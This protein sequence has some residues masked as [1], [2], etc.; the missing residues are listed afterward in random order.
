VFVLNPHRYEISIYKDFKC[1]G[2]IQGKSDVFAKAESPG[3]AKGRAF[4]FPTA[5]VQ[6][7]GRRIYVT[8]RKPAAKSGHEMDIFEDGRQIGRLT[9]SGIPYAVDAQGR[10][11]FA[12]EEGF[13]RI[14]RYIVEN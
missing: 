7:A 6:E 10:L 8:I 14:V 9:V 4:I 1:I 12:E 3:P 11:Y 5:Y 13:P 2:Q